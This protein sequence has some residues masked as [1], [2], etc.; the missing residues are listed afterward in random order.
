MISRLSEAQYL[1][2]IN[3]EEEIEKFKGTINDK[4]TEESGMR[5]PIPV[6]VVSKLSHAVSRL[7]D[8]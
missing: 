2:H 4:M 8:S 7:K 6:V 3:F 5:I 1:E